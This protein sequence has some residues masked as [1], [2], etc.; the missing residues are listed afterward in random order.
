M[1]FR[2]PMSYSYGLIYIQVLIKGQMTWFSMIDY[3]NRLAKPPIIPKNRGKYKLLEKSQYSY[4]QASISF[5]VSHGPQILITLVLM[6][7][8]EPSGHILILNT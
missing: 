3:H 7:L 4:K 2:E 1:G 6:F 5:F 8:S